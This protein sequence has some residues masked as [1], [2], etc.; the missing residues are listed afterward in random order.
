MNPCVQ[1]RATL[2]GSQAG[3]T[4]CRDRLL[5]LFVAINRLRTPGGNGYIV[6]SVDDCNNVGSAQNV[7]LLKPMDFKPR[8]EEEN[9]LDSEVVVEKENNIGG[10]TASA[11]EGFLTLESEE[12]EAV[13]KKRNQ[14]EDSEEN[15]MSL[16]SALK[17]E[18]TVGNGVAYPE[19]LSPRFVDSY[20]DDMEKLREAVSKK[21]SQSEPSEEDMLSLQNALGNRARLASADQELD[22]LGYLVD[23]KGESHPMADGSLIGRDP[24]CRLC[25]PSKTVSRKHAKVV[26]L[27]DGGPA[28]QLLNP[29]SKV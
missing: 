27:E 6:D 17:S 24:Q 15:M 22:I 25:L 7:R 11:Q 18:N 21:K 13:V 29:N 26:R 12:E 14:S 2:L 8:L 9:H 4:V 3:R 5:D 19:P 1:V 16:Q 28:L 20:N 10:N 23:L